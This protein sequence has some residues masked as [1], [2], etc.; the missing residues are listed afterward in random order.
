MSLDGNY[1]PLQINVLSEISAD[2][3]FT[4][5]PIASSLQG[6]WNPSTYTQGSVTTNTVLKSLTDSIPNIYEMANIGQISISTWRLLLGLGSSICPALGNSIPSTFKPS[7]PG[8]GSWTGSTLSSDSYPPKGYPNS[9]TYSYIYNTYGNYAYITGWPGSNSWQK[10]T[11]TYSA[12]YVPT[13]DGSLTDYDEYFSKGYVSVLARQAYYELWNGTFDQYNNIIN[14]FGQS[15]SYREQQNNQI[16]SLME[17]KKFMSGNFSNINDLTTNDLSGVT[18]SF[19]IWGEDFINTGKSIDLSNIHRFGTPSVLLLTLQKYGAITPAVSLALQ[20]AGLNTQSLN[21]IFNITYTPTYEEEK[22][23]YESFKLISGPDLYGTDSG[24]TLQL[25]CKLNN[26]TTLA[27]L[28]D[29]SKLFPNSYRSLTVPQYRTD[30]LTSKTYYFIYINDGVNPQVKSLGGQLTTDLTSILSSDLAIACGA[31][32]N[33]MQQVKNIMQIDVQKLSL[34]VIDLEL[35]NKGLSEINTTTGTA[36]SIP[37]VNT[38]LSNIALGSGNS[39]SYRQCDFYG[40]V[41]GYPYNTWLTA[42]QTILNKLS[43]SSLQSIYSNLYSLSLTPVIEPDPLDPEPDPS[44]PY[45]AELDASIVSAIS[46]A[47]A[48]IS[49]I[50]YSNTGQC[51]QLNYYWNQIGNQLFIEQRAIPYCVPIASDIG[52]STQQL[53][54]S[55]FVKSIEKYAKDNGLGESG[56]ILERISNINNLGG[57][58]IIAAM[59]EARNADRLNW[60]G[61]PPSSGISTEQSDVCSASA[62]ASLNNDGSIQSVTMTSKSEG[63]DLA[64]PPQ[65]YIYPFGYGGEL[66]PVIEQDGS[67]SELVIS[68]MGSGYPYIEISIDQ[69][70]P[71]QVPDRTGNT[72]PPQSTSFNN[73]LANV[74]TFPG[75]GPFL[76]FSENPYLPGPVTPTIP[77]DSASSSIDEAIE[78]VTICNCE[79]WNL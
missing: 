7:Y 2:R 38:M 34:S 42:V 10:D 5:N 41:S 77:S 20:Y 58:S 45:D 52:A 67:I 4:I 44:Y 59:R 14:S 66:I 35:T 13:S 1:T 76:T 68:N 31:F 62:T 40:A 26:L 63:Y 9:S 64:N 21:R 32:S 23:I 33:T 16:L 73:D 17:S 65:I 74:I 60:A 50:Y 72:V 19:R 3:G 57:Q 61:I 71:C 78:D 22:K 27:D 48:A 70:P 56:D 39:G 8:Y 55:T 79:C 75:P 6:S 53:N 43:T 15:E 29:P 69:P 51:N 37:I 49:N 46:A 47:E 30:T 24:I 54:F 11:D 25:N 18:Q 28:L 36:T 12:A